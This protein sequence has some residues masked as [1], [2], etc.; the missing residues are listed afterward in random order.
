[1]AATNGNSH[2]TCSAE[3]VMAAASGKSHELA[4]LNGQR[5]QRVATRMGRAQRSVLWQRRVATRIELAQLSGRR[6]NEWR[7]CTA[8]PT[9]LAVAAVVH[10]CSD[11]PDHEVATAGETAAGKKRRV[12]HK[13]VW[14][15]AHNYLKTASGQKRTTVSNCVW[16]EA[17]IYFKTASGQKRPRVQ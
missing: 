6:G 14:T 3:W 16:T 11:G 9:S 17:H 15:E 7:W 13:C 8:A 5:L 4:Q 12:I 2:R 1:M 10:G